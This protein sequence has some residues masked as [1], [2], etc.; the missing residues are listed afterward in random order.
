M[1]PNILKGYTAHS[2]TH[3][4][5]LFVPFVKKTSSTLKLVNSNELQAITL[6]VTTGN[7]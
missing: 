1:H 4:H 5:D 3:T 7:Q 6:Y 2:V